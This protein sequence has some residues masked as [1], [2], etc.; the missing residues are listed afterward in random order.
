MG[1]PSLSIQKKKK[2]MSTNFWQLVVKR[3][4]RRLEGWQTKVMSRGAI[5]VGTVNPF[6]DTSILPLTIRTTS[7][8]GEAIARLD[9]TFPMERHWTGIK[10]LLDNGF[11]GCHL[12]TNQAREFGD[13][14]RTKHEHDPTNI[15]GD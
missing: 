9:E 5:G 15:V 4:D 8:S 13:L 10:T 12:S 14:T 1:C 7:R 11:M 6:G 3:V 2:K